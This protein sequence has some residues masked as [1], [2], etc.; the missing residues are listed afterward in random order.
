MDMWLF[1]EATHA[2]KVFCN[3]ISEEGVAALERVLDLA[4]GTRVL[5]IACGHAELLIRFAER[6][7]TTGVGVDLSPYA[8]PRARANVATRVPDAD[9]TL[10]EGRGE[11]Y[12]PAEGETFDVAMSIGA[13]WIWNGFEGTLAALRGFARPGGLIVSGE[14][15]WK[16][17]PTPEY[18][19]IEGCTPDQFTDLHGCWKVATGMGLTPVWCRRSTDEEWDR[20]ELDQLAALDRFTRENPDHED[21]AEIRAG[22]LESKE[23]YLSWGHRELG[24]A[25]WVFRT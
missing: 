8:M 9:L 1:Y 5:D 16:R 15:Y 19:E 23:A 21:L 18:C 20:Y 22:H 7:G 12:A 11:E 4:P 2:D 17:E 24:F 13:S 14:P 25:F 3:P 10:I 6:F